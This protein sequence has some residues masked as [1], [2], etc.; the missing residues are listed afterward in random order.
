MQISISDIRLD[1]KTHARAG[2]KA[3]V[4][5]DYTKGVM[6]VNDKKMEGA[7]A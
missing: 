5:A 3:E 1:G 7:S 6:A 2:L 4:I